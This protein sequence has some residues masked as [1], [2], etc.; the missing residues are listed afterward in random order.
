V[1]NVRLTAFNKVGT[2]DKPVGK[3]LA[4]TSIQFTNG[5]GEIAARGSH[6]KY[7]VATSPRDFSKVII[8]WVTDMWLLPGSTQRTS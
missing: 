1:I 7:V 6:T 2:K 8:D 5:K 3:T 4:Y